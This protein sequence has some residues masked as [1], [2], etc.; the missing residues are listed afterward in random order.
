[1]SERLF[2]IIPAAGHSRR[3]RQPKLLLDLGGQSVLARLLSALNTIEEIEAVCLVV[4]RD[5]LALAEVAE[6]GGAT[7]LRPEHDPPEMRDS[8]EFALAEIERRFSPQSDDAWMLIP[9]DHPLIEPG[10]LRQI[11]DAWNSRSADVLIPTHQEKGGHPTLFRWSTARRIKSIPANL[12][13]NQLME[14]TSLNV[15]RIEFDAPE[16]LIDLDTPEDYERAVQ[17]WNHRQ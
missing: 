7:V 16:L 3:M 6:R 4:R 1:M 12:G 5:D 9:A 14:D 2:A 15:E 10:T 13:I 17:W 11:V 8:V